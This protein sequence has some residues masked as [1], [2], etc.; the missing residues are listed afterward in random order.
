ME[1]VALEPLKKNID[2]DFVREL[3]DE[4]H[5]K[6]GSVVAKSILDDWDTEKAKFIKV[7]VTGSLDLHIRCF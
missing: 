2:V 3:L 1:S 4:F 5:Q 7:G 6:T